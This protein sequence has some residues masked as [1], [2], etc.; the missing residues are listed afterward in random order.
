M[1]RPYPLPGWQEVGVALWDSMSEQ[2]ITKSLHTERLVPLLLL[3]DMAGY[4]RAG[5]WEK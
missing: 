2:L 1:E 4:E 5:D 3:K